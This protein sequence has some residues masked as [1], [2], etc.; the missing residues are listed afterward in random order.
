LSKNGKE[1]GRI[2]PMVARLPTLQRGLLFL[3]IYLSKA[4]AA[5]KLVLRYIYTAAYFAYKRF[6]EDSLAEILRIHPELVTAGALFDVGANVGYSAWV[7]ARNFPSSAM[8]YCFEPS[9]EN[10]SVL[11]RTVSKHKLT[12]QVE[13]IHAAV[14]ERSGEL[15]LYLNEGHPGDHKVIDDGSGRKTEMVKCWSLD[16]FATEKQLGRIALVKIDV[17]GA[18]SLVVQGMMGLLDRGQI[19]SV[20][21]E[22]SSDDRT[23]DIDRIF[24][25][26]STRGFRSFC[27]D[28]SKQCLQP[29]DAQYFIGRPMNF[30]VDILFTRIKVS[31]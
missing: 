21:V 28:P 13:L 1:A 9:E 3:F 4:P 29:M 11:S 18:E 12:E 25:V 24:Q 19:D 31:G 10:F 2:L 26:F 23:R 15:Q 20:I 27:F 30:S 17:Q 16:D 8:I 7:L 22:M 6:L 14:G 5:K